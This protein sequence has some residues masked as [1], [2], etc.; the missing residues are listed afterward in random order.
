MGT[1]HFRVAFISVDIDHSSPTHQPS[2]TAHLFVDTLI[3]KNGVLLKTG[4]PQK[5]PPAPQQKR[6]GH[7]GVP[8][9]VV[10]S[11]TGDTP[12]IDFSA[13]QAC[14]YTRRLS[15]AYPAVSTKFA[16]AMGGVMTEPF[17][18]WVHCGI[19]RITFEMGGVKKIPK[20]SKVL[21]H[22]LQVCPLVRLFS[23][24]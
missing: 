1:L 17:T 8:F 21:F 9:K 6:R 23:G 15:S 3:H 14:G 19:L 11:K 7:L 12:S 18:N 16:S 10:P 2:R 24:V 4:Q 20:C 22:A 13:P 5:Y